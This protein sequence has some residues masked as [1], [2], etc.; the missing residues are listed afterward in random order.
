M[1]NADTSTHD[2]D[3]ALVRE[4][5]PFCF[6]LDASM[7]L[8]MTGARWLDFD[9]SVCVGASFFELF[10]IERPLNVLTEAQISQCRDDVFLL[11]LR[12]RPATKLRGQFVP[13]EK[14]GQTNGLLFVGGPWITRI[15]ELS[16]NGLSLHDFPPHD[17]RGD[18]LVLLQ[19]QE[20]TLADLKLLAARLRATG[21]ALETRTSDLERELEVRAHLEAQLRQGQKMEAIGRLAGGVAHDFNN[22]L[23]AIHGYAALS[24]SRVA[25]SDPVR[26][27]LEQIRS[28]ADLAATLTRQLLT[29][30]RQHVLRPEALDIS[31]EVRQVEKLL[32]P[33]VG[34]RINM[35]IHA[36]S[37]LGS[38]WA[39]PS[40]IQQIV[41]NLALN[42]CDA[43]PSGGELEISVAA[44]AANAQGVLPNQA[45]PDNSL[46]SSGS[47][48]GALTSNGLTSNGFIELRVRD[49]GVG[50][51]EATKSRI[52]EPFYTTKEVGKGSGLGLSIVY[53]LVEQCGGTITIESEIGHGSMFRVLFPRVESQAPR[54][55]QP[56][57]SPVGGRGERVLLVEDEALVRRLLD[58]LLT[59]AG[60]QVAPHSDP[61]Q[62]LL[63]VE[64]EKAQ[65]FELVITDVVMAGMSGPELSHRIEAAHGAVPTI[66]MSGHTEDEMFRAGGMAAHQRFM[67]KPFAPSELLTMARD[68]LDASRIKRTSKS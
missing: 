38:A 6:A 61:A 43:M 42:A 7:R 31:N 20:S 47:T 37:D 59:R 51:D 52:F 21:T 40:A 41:M 53:G 57:V 62:A 4:L 17:P 25:P 18:F 35:H 45:A 60:Y 2:G 29:F 30:S 11:S 14:S 50:M 56:T 48:G 66:F 39:D 32:R 33:L 3:G 64:R 46:T 68:L 24:L 58:Q 49:T 1:T 16:S 67:S 22:I 19:T 63:T 36:P 12:A 8:C 15:T 26:N 54:V 9:A 27:W 34:A 23:M 28:A 44:I 55:V 10:E 5:F 65:P 13:R